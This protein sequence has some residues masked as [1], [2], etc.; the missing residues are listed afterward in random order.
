MIWLFHSLLNCVYTPMEGNI[1]Q[2]GHNQTVVGWVVTPYL[3]STSHPL[4]PVSFLMSPC[5]R[6][7]S[8]FTCVLLWCTL[9]STVT[10]NFICNIF[11]ITPHMENFYCKYPTSPHTLNSWYWGD[12]FVSLWN[13]FI[14]NNFS[15]IK[16]NWWKRLSYVLLS[17]FVSG[18][19]QCI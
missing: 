9:L 5:L 18:I 11:W 2:E 7:S 10:G 16:S 19:I 3:P 8:H 15:Q 4:P 12:C 17:F 1:R 13:T 14:R 6:A